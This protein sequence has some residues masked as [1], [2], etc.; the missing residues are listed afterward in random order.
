MTEY[1]QIF[2]GRDFEVYPSATKSSLITKRNFGDLFIGN[3]K[4]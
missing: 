3:I 2:G 1:K 4:N